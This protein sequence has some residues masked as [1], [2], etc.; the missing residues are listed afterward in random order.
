V[1]ELGSATAAGSELAKLQGA[2]VAGPLPELDVEAIRAAQDT[3]RTLVRSGAAH[4]AHDIAEGGI[5]VA[6]AECCI[7]GAV[8]A[9]VRLPEGVDPFAEAPGRA[10][11]VSGSEDAL[12]G[13]PVIG[14]VGGTALS[15]EGLLSVAVVTL[16]ETRRRGL[17]R[18][19]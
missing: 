13:L 15:V 14:R 12:R 2:P 17:E 9:S 6:L 1:G 5:A 18:F 4:S 16:G 10:F 7:A 3:V 11:I 8:G 19:M